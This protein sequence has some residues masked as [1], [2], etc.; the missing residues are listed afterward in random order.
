MENQSS[1]IVEHSRDIIVIVLLVSSSLLTWLLIVLRKNWSDMEKWR[2][3]MDICM[4]G[5]PGE[6]D[7]GIKQRLTI[8]ET[9][10]EERDCRNKKKK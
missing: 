8:L 2:D 6:P 1:L 4:Y 3:K 10:C 5:V 7:S 9:K